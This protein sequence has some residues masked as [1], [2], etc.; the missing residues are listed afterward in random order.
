MLRKAALAFLIPATFA[1]NDMG[2]AQTT[3]P[4]TLGAPVPAA[5]ERPESHLLEPFWSSAT[6]RGEG[7]LFVQEKEG[8]RPVAKLLFEP[9]VG[10]SLCNASGTTTYALGQDYVVDAKARTISLPVGSKIPFVTTA[11]LNPPPGSPNSMGGNIDGK[12]NLLWS[13][14]HFFHDLQVEAS[15]RHAKNEWAGYV[16]APASNLPATLGKLKRKEPLHIVLLGDSISEGYNASS[17]V[18]VEPMMPPY[19]ELVRSA[20]QESS[21]SPVTLK[22]LAVAGKD[23]EWGLTQIDAVIAA[24]PDLV[25][26]AFGMNDSGRF[27][28][29]T[30]I[31]NIKKHIDGI[32]AQCP[33]AEFIL[34]ASSLPNASWAA[35]RM[36]RFPLYRDELKSLTGPGITLADLTQTWT[37]V[38]AR[39]KYLDLTGNGL[40]HP[41]DFGHRLYT[42]VILGLLATKQNN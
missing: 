2:Q 30:Y 40:N 36:D 34:V 20:L 35:V 37:D 26:L 32:K 19:G 41:N 13:E 10:L 25:I 17:H 15:Y 22:N 12:N 24:K 11:A 38:I 39:K 6:M 21:G 33:N 29:A 18:K 1:L 23:S 5:P 27:E 4:A 28:P 9:L 42:Q 8:E 3:P 31:A 7:L 14:G 16:P